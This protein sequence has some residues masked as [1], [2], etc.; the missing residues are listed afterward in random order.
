MT[1]REQCSLC[2]H[3]RSK[4]V[5]GC[6]ESSYFETTVDAGG[7]CDSFALSLGLECFKN[8]F[9]KVG[10]TGSLASG[11]PGYEKAL[12]YGLPED[13]ELWVRFWLAKGYLEVVG[14]SDVPSEEKAKLPE[15]SRAMDQLE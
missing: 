5:C 9:M 14:N 12:E 15:A 10:E 13:D 4:K 11:I 7:Y 8:A 3:I 2:T 6:S 1:D